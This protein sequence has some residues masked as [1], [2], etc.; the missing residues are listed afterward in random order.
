M[1]AGQRYGDNLKWSLRLLGGLAQAHCE[2]ADN[3]SPD[4]AILC[5]KRAVETLPQD[6]TGPRVSMVGMFVAIGR[7]IKLKSCPVHN[8][9]LFDWYTRH[10]R[11]GYGSKERTE[12]RVA[13]LAVWHPTE[14][15]GLPLA[16][17]ILR[18]WPNNEIW[19]A[20][21]DAPLNSLGRDLL[22]AS[23]ILRRQGRASQADGLDLIIQ[24]R[25]PAIWA[26]R[27]RLAILK[28]FDDDLRLESARQNSFSS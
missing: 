26:D 4:S 16:Q 28:E 1:L 8:V 5:L 21:R 10:L 22:R 6:H 24:T 15:N 12:Q 19:N 7:H 2:W 11:L 17:W 9:V 23:Y 27:A 18:D 14:P 3:S 20:R 13:R 25:I